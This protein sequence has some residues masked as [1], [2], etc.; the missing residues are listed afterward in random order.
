MTVSFKSS[1]HREFADWLKEGMHGAVRGGLTSAAMRTLSH[2]TTVLIPMQDPQPVDTGAYRA[3]WRVDVTAEGADL[4]N[5]LPYA[6]IIEDGARP[7]NV[8]IGR[9]MIAALKAWVLRKGFFGL[10]SSSKK[11]ADSDGQAESMAWAIAVAMKKRGIFNRMG[12][13][14]LGIARAARDFAISV[15]PEEVER[16]VRRRMR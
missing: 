3:G 1:E 7:E 8:K 11:K 2:V 4:V 9:A 5:T 15:I 16:E 12:K 14:G 6:T 13:K 10:D